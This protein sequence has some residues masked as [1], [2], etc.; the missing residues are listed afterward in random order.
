M[1]E[2]YDS[3]FRERM[4]FF[5]CLRR[6]LPEVLPSDSILDY[7]LN[8]FLSNSKFFNHMVPDIGRLKIALEFF[9]EFIDFILNKFL[10]DSDF[11]DRMT[12][13]L[14]FSDQTIDIK[15]PNSPPELLISAEKLSSIQ[16]EIK[17]KVDKG[18]IGTKSLQLIFAFLDKALNWINEKDFVVEMKSVINDQSQLYK[19]L[20]ELHNYLFK[21]KIYGPLESSAQNLKQ[22]G[23]YADNK[24]PSI[25]KRIHARGIAPQFSRPLGLTSEVSLQ[26]IP[27]NA[28]SN[29]IKNFGQ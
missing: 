23:I 4:A 24:C 7:V 11:F 19:N 21:A 29:K 26:P 6:E 20:V 27:D 10:T 2:E 28:A 16:N 25:V 14:S 12:L 18:A 17:A 22:L 15:S 1:I 13:H 8:D 9:P 3:D 5:F